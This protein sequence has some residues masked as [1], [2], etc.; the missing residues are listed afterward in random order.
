MEPTRS[1]ASEGAG[2]DGE[3]VRD[4]GFPDR[5]RGNTP[6]DLKLEANG[7]A[8]F[9]VRR[10]QEKPNRSVCLG[11][12]GGTNAAINETNYE[13]NDLEM[14]AQKVGANAL[15]ELLL[16]AADEKRRGV[17]GRGSPLGF[18]GTR[19]SDIEAGE[20]FLSRPSRALENSDPSRRCSYRG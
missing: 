12:T 7:R 20:S 16:K 14:L 17:G 8:A 9:S 1:S 13:R 18:A 11:P 6:V 4:E 3:Y 2:D 5:S 15:I 19:S 10:S